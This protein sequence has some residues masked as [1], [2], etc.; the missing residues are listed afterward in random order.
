MDDNLP[1]IMPM[2]FVLLVPVLIGN[3]PMVFTN[4]KRAGL[5]NESH[6]LLFR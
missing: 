4:V 2:F 6:G 3:L 5:Q 1:Q